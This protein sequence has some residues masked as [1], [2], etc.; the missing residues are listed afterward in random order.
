MTELFLLMNAEHKK[1]KTGSGY[2]NLTLSNAERQI[3]GKLWTDDIDLVQ[4]IG[5]VLKMSG[6]LG[7]YNG[8]P[9]FT[10]EQFEV[11][12][13][14]PCEMCVKTKFD[15][16]GMMS[17]VWSLTN[18]ID[19]EE[20]RQLVNT[21]FTEHEDEFAKHTGAQMNHHAFVGGLLQHTLSVATAACSLCK[22][23][24]VADRDIVIAAA[25]LHDVGKLFELSNFPAVSFT[26]LGGCVG[27]PTL[28]VMEI[29]KHIDMLHDDFKR[30]KLLN[31]VAAHHGRREWGAAVL[32]I[33]I[34]AWI[35]HTCDML[36]AQVEMILEKT[37]DVPHGELSG[38][39]P[40]RGSALL[41]V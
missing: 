26:R 41:G 38:Y 31:C 16:P 12:D 32:P 6:E 34:E 23:Y 9:Q 5:Q 4:Y 25:L 37:A 1:T 20:I 7:E 15:I 29:T 21:I 18:S 39:I 8:M 11:T 17:N 27:H 33:C 2:Y 30:D 13:M 28:S 10:V 36:D 14:D 24:K 3:G 35:V 40:A 19:D 22:I